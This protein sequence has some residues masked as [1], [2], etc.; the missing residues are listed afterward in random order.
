MSKIRG[1]HGQYDMEGQHGTRPKPSQL[2][3]GLAGPTPLADRPGPGKFPKNVFT[4]W[5]SKSVRG[6]S[7]VGNTVERLNL[8]ARPSCM[9]DRPNKWASRAQSSARALPYSSYKYPHAP[10]SRKCEESE[11]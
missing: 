7:N 11:V 2:K 4:T 1:V 10:P 9:A 6:V 5:Q 3:V 8:A